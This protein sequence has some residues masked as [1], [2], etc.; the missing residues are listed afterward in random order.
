MSAKQPDTT[1]TKEFMVNFFNHFEPVEEKIVY[2]Y[3]SFSG[4][5]G[6]I[7]SKSLFM[8]NY[9]HL[10]DPSEFSFAFDKIM[11]KI[12]EKCV[13][14]NDIFW[15]DLKISLIDKKKK[16][17]L[18]VCSFCV[19]KDYLPAWRLYADDGR[20]FS[21]GFR[22]EFISRREGSDNRL[23]PIS[24]KISYGDAIDEALKNIFSDIDRSK[25]FPELDLALHAL[26]SIIYSRLKHEA[27]KEEKEFRIGQLTMTGTPHECNDL[28]TWYSPS[29]EAPFVA[30]KSKMDRKFEIEDIVEIVIGPRNN[31]QHSEVEIRKL[32]EVNGFDLGKISIKRSEIPYQNHQHYFERSLTQRD[33][34]ETVEI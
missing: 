22:R 20:G 11:D 7:R 25:K 13:E 12:D 8:T 14:S 17:S 29:R 23:L 32:L 34:K 26:F 24:H 3:T 21:I 28:V 16:M 9:I 6:I 10:N 4:L 19:D 31:F 30:S 18:Y 5:D 15:K 1:K 2:H 27:Y 33:V